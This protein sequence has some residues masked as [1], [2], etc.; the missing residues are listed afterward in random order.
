MTTPSNRP[1]EGQPQP[2]PEQTERMRSVEGIKA[3]LANLRAAIE[4]PAPA[5]PAPAENAEPQNTDTT[6]LT[7]VDT[8]AQAVTRARQ[9]HANLGP[10]DS[11]RIEW[12]DI[13]D[14]LLGQVQGPSLEITRENLVRGIEDSLERGEQAQGELARLA[15]QLRGDTVDEE[16]A[17]QEYLDRFG[18]TPAD[19]FDGMIDRVFSRAEGSDAGRRVLDRLR[20]FGVN[21]DDVRNLIKDFFFRFAEGLPIR[22]GMVEDSRFRQELSRLN[23]QQRARIAALASGQPPRDVEQEWRSAYE[24]WVTTPDKRIQDRPRIVFRGDEPAIFPNPTE[25]QAQRQQPEVQQNQNLHGINGMALNQLIS[26]QGRAETSLNVAG[27]PVGL[28]FGEISRL[29][30]RFVLEDPSSNNAVINITSIKALS[31]SDPGQTELQLSIGQTITLAEL[32]RQLDAGIGANRNVPEIVAPIT[33]GSR[34]INA[35]SRA[36]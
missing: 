19:R 4:R 1:P 12:E 15:A 20:S 33:I 8:L 36:S 28:T 24:L 11:A 34:T 26:M 3:Q 18:A 17:V 27:S 25:Q 2:S 9:L 29:Q 7:A 14:A 21:M 5:A 13:E 30:R 16:A 31:A 6:V 23:R 32:V 22:V 35:R 10:A